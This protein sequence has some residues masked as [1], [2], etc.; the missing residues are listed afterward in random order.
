MSAPAAPDTAEHELALWEQLER[1]QTEVAR[2]L[3]RT[4]E[5][6]HG[7]TVHGFELLDAI[8]SA[9]TRRLRMSELAARTLLTPSGVTRLVARLERD[10]VVQRVDCREDGRVTYA[11]LTEAGSA[12]LDAARETHRAAVHA[13]LLERFSVDDLRELRHALERARPPETG[14][15]VD[16]PP[17]AV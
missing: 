8:A 17:S 11:Q 14:L 13:L 16:Q 1:L 6:E 12:K 9:P 5:R 3:D 10:G 4:L 7:L 15:G 2:T